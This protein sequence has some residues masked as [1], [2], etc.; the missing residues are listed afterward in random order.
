[1]LRSLAMSMRGTTRQWCCRAALAL[2]LGAMHCG[3]PPL[4]S[5]LDRPLARAELAQLWVERRDSSSLDL[6]YG[7]GGR[8]LAPD[9]QARYEIISKKHDITSSSPGYKVRDPSGLKWNVKLGAETQ[10]EVLASRLIWAAGYHQPPVYYVAHWQ[11]YADGTATPQPPARFRPMLPRCKRRD[12]WSWHQNPFV[13]TR[14]FRGLIVLMLMLNNWDLTT[15]NNSIYDL[16]QEWD[17]AN[18]WYVV[19]DVGASFSRTRGAWLQGTRGDPEGFARQGFIE[20]VKDGRVVFAW[21]GPNQELIQNITPDD[22]RWIADRLAPLTPRQWEDAFQ[23][24]GYSP[25]EADLI[26]RTLTDRI[27]QARSL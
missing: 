7:I 8:D 14:P 22:V 27:A 20:T 15:A 25:A 13:G 1:M 2:A 19:R 9:P 6:L 11:T 24:A 18:L 26:R 17:G 4:R 23:A 21:S 10:A 3:A 5:T 12:G 16:P